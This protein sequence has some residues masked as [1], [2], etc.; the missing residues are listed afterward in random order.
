MPPVVRAHMCACVHD[1]ETV[2]TPTC[3]REEGRP[4]RICIHTQRACYCRRRAPDTELRQLKVIL[5]TAVASP[6]NLALDSTPHC[7]L[8][9]CTFARACAPVQ[10]RGAAHTEW[11]GVP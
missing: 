8:S 1:H 9:L 11:H 6:L 5:L 7:L 3:N 4:W 10:A 2:C